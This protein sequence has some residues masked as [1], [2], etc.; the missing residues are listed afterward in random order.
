MQTKPKRQQQRT[1]QTSKTRQ[2]T[3]KIVAKAVTVRKDNLQKKS[4][5]VALFFYL[6]FV[7]EFDG[8]LVN[9]MFGKLERRFRL[10]LF[11]HCAVFGILDGVAESG[12]F[13]SYFIGKCPVFVCLGLCPFI[14]KRH[15]FGGG[16]V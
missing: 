11:N 12:D 1:Q 14:D 7:F 9:L 4:D 13:G 15:N 2:Q 8:Y 5:N 6:F 3:Q 16:V 10:Q